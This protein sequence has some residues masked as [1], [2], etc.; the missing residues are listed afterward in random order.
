MTKL[1]LNGDWELRNETG[2]TLCPVKV[3]GSVISGLYAAGRIE[4][5]YYRENEYATR[6]LFQKDYEFVRQFE[7][8]RALWEEKELKLICEG[9]DTLTQIYI[10]GREIASTDNMHRT[11]SLYDRRPAFR[12]RFPGRFR[13]AYEGYAQ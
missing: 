9:L 7:V 5:P 10:N 12:L 8:S 4:H 3:P 13:G 6:E 1:E 11:Y 2:E